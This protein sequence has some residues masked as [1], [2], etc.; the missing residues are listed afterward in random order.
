MKNYKAEVENILTKSKLQDKYKV[1]ALRTLFREIAKEAVDCE[2][3]ENRRDGDR[4]Q[5]MIA[6][7]YNIARSEF[8]SNIEKLIK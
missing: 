4:D 5:E 6:I 2:K 8:L 3:N 7:G 1:N